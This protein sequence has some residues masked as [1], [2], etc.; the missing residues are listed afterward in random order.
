MKT[1]FLYI[2]AILTFSTTSCTSDGQNEESNSRKVQ[3]FAQEDRLEGQIVAIDN[4]TN[5]LVVNS[6]TYN[7]NINSTTE[8]IAYFDKK[9]TMVKVEEKFSDMKSGNFGSTIFYLE[10]GKK[11]ATKQLYFDNK[12]DQ[13]TF[14]ERISFYDKSEKVN[15]TKERLAPFEEE[16]VDLPFQ[17]AKLHDCSLERAMSILNQTGKFV[18]TFQGFASDGNTQYLLVGENTVEG[19][20]SSLA[21]QRSDATIKKLEIDEKT[22]IGTPLEVQYYQMV[23]ERGLKFQVLESVIIK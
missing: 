12:M 22:M 21:V 16:L 7:N 14:V 5:L 10:N 18:T 3:K 9:E 17:P 15:Y 19:Y 2:L 20:A 11:I 13:P 1:Q 8:V 6:L 23:D 4:N